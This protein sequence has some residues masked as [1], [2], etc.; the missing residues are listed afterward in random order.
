MRAAVR[1]LNDMVCKEARGWTN[2]APSTSFNPFAA[3]SGTSLD[4]KGPLL[5]GL[6]QKLWVCSLRRWLGG[7]SIERSHAAGKHRDL[8]HTHDTQKATLRPPCIIWS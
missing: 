5:M 6:G 8:T 7:A 2:F 4:L 3:P 1:S